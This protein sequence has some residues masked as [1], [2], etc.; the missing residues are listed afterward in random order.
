MDSESTK[1]E[2]ERIWK[3]HRES[4]ADDPILIHP[5]DQRFECK[6][7]GWP[8]LG[9]GKLRLFFTENSWYTLWVLF[10]TTKFSIAV[11]FGGRASTR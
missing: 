7:R 3:E 2:I 1:K 9:I 8:W 5:P 6:I 10:L 11:H 4:G